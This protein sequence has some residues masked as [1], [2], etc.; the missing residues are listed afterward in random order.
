LGVVLVALGYA[1]VARNRDYRSTLTIWQDTV[2]RRAGNAFAHYNL[3]RELYA[4]GRTDEALEHYREAVRLDPNDELAQNGLGAAL[5]RT[6][7]VAEAVE[8]YREAVRLDFAQCEAQH[9]LGLALAQLGQ[10]DEALECFQ[11]ALMLQ[12]HYVSAHYNLANLLTRLGRTQEAIEHYDRVLQTVPDD[13][14]VLAKLAWLLATIEPARGGDPLRAVQLAE[15]A[16]RV[17]GPEDAQRLDTLATAYAAAG[18]FAE[19]ASAAEK[20]LQMA[21]STEHTALCKGIRSR[22]EAYRAG[23]SYHEIPQPPSD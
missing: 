14:K 5:H 8:H 1:T 15:H 6:G 21:D 23:R 16:C 13:S 4:L 10:T 20:A 3:G 11:A 12:P 22:L 18:R 9:N 7:E 17:K 2:K 19:A